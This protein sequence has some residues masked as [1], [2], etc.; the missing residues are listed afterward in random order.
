MGVIIDTPKIRMEIKFVSVESLFIHEETIP[1]ALQQLIQDLTVEGILKHPI[2]VDTETNVVLD[3]MHRVAA[4]KRL[5]CKIV[6]VCNVDYKNPEIELFAWYREF[7]GNSSFDILLE[8]ICS[9]EQFDPA[10]T[11]STQAHELVNSRNAMAALALGETA[12]LLSPNT[13]LTI[14]EI[15]DK[16]AAIEIKAQQLQ[17][18]IIYST[19]TDA[20][21][22]LQEHIRPVLLVPSLTKEEVVE[23]A[24][25]HQLF[26][27]KTTRHVVPARPLF[28]NVPI[29]WLKTVN[30]KE[31]N[32][33]LDI[34]LNSKRIIKKDPGAIIDGRRYE[35]RAYL[36]SDP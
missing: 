27:Q 4:L 2:I 20:L 11:S 16:I 13:Q 14:K 35:E 33:Q 26:T 6:P 9:E 19:E 1:Q 22:S 34:H 28:T 18:S 25:K 32:R 23:S 24:L 10:Q 8:K 36:F 12:F 21:K 15:Y 30:L 3:G 7:N 17:Y 29:S 31:A 5:E